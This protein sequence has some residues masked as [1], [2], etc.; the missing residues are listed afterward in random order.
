MHLVDDHSH[1][2]CCNMG[3]AFCCCGAWR[4]QDV[5]GTGRRSFAVYTHFCP[6]VNHVKVLFLVMQCA[7]WQCLTP[8][9]LTVRFLST[10]SVFVYSNPLIVK[11]DSKLAQRTSKHSAEAV[12]EHRM[13]HPSC[14]LTGLVS[15]ALKHSWPLS[16][17]MPLPTTAA[18]SRA[19][20]LSSW[21]GGSPTLYLPG[22]TSICCAKQACTQL[23]LVPPACTPC[24]YPL[25]ASIFMCS[26]KQARTAVCCSF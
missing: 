3:C 1:A 13:L 18:C 2:F 11:A 19:R 22:S 25:L 24:L 16:S 10:C 5:A 15:N 20:A 12:C 9:L 21:P 7:V 4:W 23:S 17:S 8:A 14:L 6:F 26:S